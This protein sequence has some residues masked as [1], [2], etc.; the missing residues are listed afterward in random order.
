[1]PNYDDYDEHEPTCFDIGISGNCDIECPVL[2][3]GDCDNVDE[4]VISDMIECY[5]DD[6]E[7]LDELLDL[8]GFDYEAIVIGNKLEELGL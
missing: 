8:Y 1:M 4:D 6:K 2:L 5:K 3:S 7:Y